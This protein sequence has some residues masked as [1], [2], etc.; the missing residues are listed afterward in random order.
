MYLAVFP[1]IFLRASL[2]SGPGAT[3]LLRFACRTAQQQDGSGEVQVCFPEGGG[4]AGADCDFGPA[5]CESGLCIRKDSGPLCTLPCPS[6]TG[7]P[8]SW[9]CELTLTVT[10]QSIQACIPPSLLP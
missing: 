4:K 8:E 2:S 6:G 1:T 5:A 9:S 10:D 7:C 3:G